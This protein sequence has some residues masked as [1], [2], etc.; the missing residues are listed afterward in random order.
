VACRGGQWL[1]LPPVV[2][3]DA[4]SPARRMASSR[5]A[6]RSAR[7]GTCAADPKRLRTLPIGVRSSGMIDGRARA[8]RKA[9]RPS[10]CFSAAMK[11]R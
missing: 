11:S 1:L 5:P 9:V 4:A 10:L 2:K 3:A 7:P 8:S 6:R